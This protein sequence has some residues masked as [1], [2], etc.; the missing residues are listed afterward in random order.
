MKSG[1]PD[2]DTAKPWPKPVDPFRATV[3]ENPT[4][5]YGPAELLSEPWVKTGSLDFSPGDCDTKKYGNCYSSTNFVLL[6]M[7]L[8]SQSGASSWEKFD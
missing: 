7:I 3:Y 1:V 8:A 2:F 4:K 5:V 6:G